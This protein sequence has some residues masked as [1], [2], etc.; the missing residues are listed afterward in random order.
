MFED[1]TSF[2]ADLVVGADGE[3]VSY[4]PDELHDPL[5]DPRFSP[6]SGQLK[7]SKEPPWSAR[8]LSTFSVA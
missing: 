6:L 4:V 8:V 1:G 5:P 3:N 7:G 2:A